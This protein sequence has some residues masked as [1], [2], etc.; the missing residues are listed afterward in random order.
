MQETSLYSDRVEDECHHLHHI[1]HTSLVNLNQQTSNL[2]TTA[3]P[4]LKGQSHA[5]SNLI[6]NS[7][8]FCT[9]PYSIVVYFGQ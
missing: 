2:Q 8:L 1:F 3:I 4:Q 5:K 7:T 6:D 9:I